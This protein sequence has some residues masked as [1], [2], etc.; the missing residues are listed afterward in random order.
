MPE[1]AI[2][3]VDELIALSKSLGRPEQ[4]SALCLLASIQGSGAEEAQKAAGEEKLLQAEALC[5][6]AQEQLVHKKLPAEALATSQKVLSIFAA[7]GD[8]VGQAAAGCMVTTCHAILGQ[9]S[10]SLQ[11]AEAARAACQTTEDKAGEVLARQCHI[12]AALTASRP[13]E[14]LAAARGLVGLCRHFE[15]QSAEA[16][17]LVELARLHVACDD[18]IQGVRCAEEALATAKSAPLAAKGAALAGLARLHR[19]RDRPAPARRAAEKVK[20]LP[21]R[22]ANA[23]APGRAGEARALLLA[24]TLGGQAALGLASD[25]QTLMN[26]VRDKVGEASANLARAQILAQLRDFASAAEAAQEAATGFKVGSCGVGEGVARCE[27]ATIQLL[28]EDKAE[29]EKTAKEA[30]RAFHQIRQLSGLKSCSA[31][32]GENRARQLLSHAQLSCLQPS[33]ARL[34]LDEFNCAHLEISE[35]ASQESLESAVAT[36]HNMQRLRNNVKAVVLHLEGAVG[37]ASMHSQALTS[38][39]FLVGLRAIS[40]PIVSAAYGKITGPSWN[41]LLACDYRI[42]AV[43]TSFVLPI[44]SPPECLGELVGAAMASQLCISSG[45]LDAH[46]LQELG[47]LNQVRPNK[48][49]TGRAASE[50]AKRIAAFPGIACRQ[51]MSLLTVPPVKYTT[52]GAYKLPDPDLIA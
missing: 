31:Q 20:E 8:G 44:V 5:C 4:V 48:D 26:G 40:I 36:L 28:M 45:V 13:A 33:N 39:N 42:A 30:L 21:G 3:T 51:T 50:L 41:L 46:S 34:Y 19:C 7:L 47:I 24:A 16:W 9:V 52:V 10:E 17:A 27:L 2:Q 35:T 18:P 29:A 1:Q 49:E 43:D 37:P 12:L 14:A 23:L 11:A 38:G 15:D 22:G 6:L 25:A 32:L